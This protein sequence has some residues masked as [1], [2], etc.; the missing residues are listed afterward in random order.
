VT[1][2]KAPIIGSPLVEAY[3]AALGGVLT[4]PEILFGN[5]ALV[6][7]HEASGVTLAFSALDA[8]RQWVAD[9]LPPLKVAVAQE[10]QAARA[11]EIEAQ[12]ALVLDYDWTYTTSYAGTLSVQGQQQ[13]QQQQQQQRQHG[14]DSIPQHQQLG[15]AGALA[16]THD[17]SSDGTS[18]QPTQQQQAPPVWQPSSRQIDRAML[19]S[20]AEPILFYADVPLY[21]S[22]LDD[23]GVC[24]CSVK[25]R[26]GA[27]VGPCCC[28]DQGAPLLSD[29]QTHTCS[30]KLARSGLAPCAR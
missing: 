24:Q 4:L 1:A 13:Q 8:L 18:Q 21:E 15:P 16:A 30:R 23:N 29:R 10:W 7:R 25:V 20:K 17:S 12:Q 2:R 6:L 26:Q 27:V 19:M 22:E 9:D 14:V 11:Q 5:S 3:A 28:C